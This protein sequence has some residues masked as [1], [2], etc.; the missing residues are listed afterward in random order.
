MNRSPDLFDSEQSTFRESNV[1][2]A[3]LCL[4]RDHTT[5]HSEYISLISPPSCSFRPSFFAF[6]PSW[7]QLDIQ[8]SRQER[9]TL[10]QQQLEFMTGILTSTKEDCMAR[11]A[12]LR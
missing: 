8:M 7:V 2:P 12:Q 1:L 10:N 3:H 11:L 9:V 5:I 4:K 6:L